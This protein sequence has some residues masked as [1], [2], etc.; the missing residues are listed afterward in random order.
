MALA[1]SGEASYWD[2]QIERDRGKKLFSKE[3][4]TLKA[5]LS[6]IIQS[7]R[8]DG[9]CDC[10]EEQHG[11]GEKASQQMLSLGKPPPGPPCPCDELIPPLN[12]D[13]RASPS[14]QLPDLS[15]NHSAPNFSIR[16]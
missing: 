7:R 12:S 4:V 3:F 6:D 5:R 1:R 14:P 15:H 9:A 8:G 11:R 16:Y 2:L 13:E 10:L